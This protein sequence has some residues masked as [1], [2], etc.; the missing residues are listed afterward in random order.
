MTGRFGTNTRFYASASNRHE[1][2]AIRYLNGFTRNAFRINV[3]QGIGTDW[4]LSFRTSYARSEADGINQEEGGNAF[5]RLTRV[6][7]IANILEYDTLGRLYI[8]PNLQ[9]GGS[10]NQNPLSTLYQTKRLDVTNRF[11]GGVTATFSPVNWFN[12]DGNFSYD[13][14]RGAGSQINDK[15]FRTTSAGTANLGSILRGTANR[16]AINGV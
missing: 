11:I 9:G 6:P 3:D 15:G 12:L 7:A 8:R 13:L 1:E 10:Q 5:F 2:G 16:E 14:R 4:N